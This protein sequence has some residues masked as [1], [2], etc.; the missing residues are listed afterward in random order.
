[1]WGMITGEEWAFSIRFSAF[2]CVT[3]S[4]INKSQKFSRNIQKAFI[5]VIDENNAKMIEL[6][7]LCLLK[8]KSSDIPYQ[9]MAYLSRINIINDQQI[10]DLLKI[11]QN[12]IKSNDNVPKELLDRL[13]SEG[14]DNQNES[15]RSTSV[16]L[17][18]LYKEKC[19]NIPKEIAEYLEFEG[20]LILLNTSTEHKGIKRTLKSLLK[21][22]FSS[23]PLSVRLLNTILKLLS[24]DDSEEYVDFIIELITNF[25]ENNIKVTH[26]F[27]DGVMSQYKRYKDKEEYVQ[28]LQVFVH[29]YDQYNNPE[30]MKY[31]LE[32]FSESSESIQNL[33]FKI[34]SDLSKRNVWFDE[35]YLFA[36]LNLVKDRNENMVF[37]IISNLVEKLRKVSGNFI[38][39]I[40]NFFYSNKYRT[41]IW[42]VLAKITKKSAKVSKKLVDKLM[43][44]S[45]KNNED[46]KLVFEIFMN[47]RSNRYQLPEDA[48][49]F[50]DFTL[51]INI[52]NN[53][54]ELNEN[55]QNSI[56]ILATLIKRNAFF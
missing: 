49:I 20:K 51:N 36:L 42:R 21:I 26:A 15:I 8:C 10:K 18:E 32:A 5:V 44:Y 31:A 29:K 12:Y 47:L 3:Y 54:D 53:D 52:L 1:M 41:N 17:L 46:S 7:V 24:N 27:I 37:K 55:K 11:M 45:Q 34:I 9:I 38:E 39:Q 14:S 40:S 23:T 4:I 19:Q 2:K 25:N 35:D 16:K 13:I 6:E 22:D 56:N 48:Q 43:K 28:L 33:W 30:V 50:A